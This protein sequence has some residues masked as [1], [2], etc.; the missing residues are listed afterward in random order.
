[1][2]PRPWN[3]ASELKA[4]LERGDLDF[5]ITLAEELRIERGRPIDLATAARF[6]PLVA[7]DRP[8]D[9][10]EWGLRWLGRWIGEAPDATLDRAAEVAAALADLPPEPRAWERLREWVGLP[11]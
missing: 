2:G 4:A 9:F 11:A 7:R 10:D 3:P 8:H 5:A 1:M 6:L